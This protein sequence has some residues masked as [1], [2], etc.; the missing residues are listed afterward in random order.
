MIGYNRFHRRKPYPFGWYYKGVMMN[1]LDPYPTDL[2]EPV[3][4]LYR[5][6]SGE[7]V[8]LG[9]C[10]HAAYQ[11]EGVCLG[12]AYPDGGVQASRSPVAIQPVDVTDEQG[13]KVLEEV[14][15]KYHSI[16]G[17][18]TAMAPR[19]ILTDLLLQQLLSLARKKLQEWLSGLG[20]KTT[21]Q[22]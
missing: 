19:S 18:K 1:S 15:S 9:E 8:P 21:A 4:I 7:D 12:S 5:K 14:V 22:E 6:M 16:K 2:S 13:K 3:S 11:V 17:T 10:I 20:G